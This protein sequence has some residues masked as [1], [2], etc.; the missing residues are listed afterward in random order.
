MDEIIVISYYSYR[1]ARMVGATTVL[2]SALVKSLWAEL[3]NKA[4]VINRDNHTC[5]VFVY[6]EF[7]QDEHQAVQ[8]SDGTAYFGVASQLRIGNW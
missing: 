4:G 1:K 3:V 5:F 2:P 6:K 8:F 7:R